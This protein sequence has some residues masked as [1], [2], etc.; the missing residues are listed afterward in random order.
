MV[1]F[2]EES[3]FVSARVAPEPVDIEKL[4]IYNIMKAISV[5]H[6]HLFNSRNSMPLEREPREKFQPLQLKLLV[7]NAHRTN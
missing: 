3:F 7:D 4:A 1:K 5:R 6:I 2:F